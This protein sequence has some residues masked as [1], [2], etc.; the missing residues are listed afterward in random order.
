MT[1]SSGTLSQFKASSQHLKDV[2][3]F[4]TVSQPLLLRSPKLLICRSVKSIISPCAWARCN[5]FQ[6]RRRGI[7]MPNIRLKV[8]RYQSWAKDEHDENLRAQANEQRRPIPS[9]RMV[10]VYCAD[11]NFAVKRNVHPKPIW[12]DH[13][14]LV[15]L[16]VDYMLFIPYSTQHH[17]PVW[18]FRGGVLQHTNPSASSLARSLCHTE[19]DGFCLSIAAAA[20]AATAKK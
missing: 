16:A 19:A 4:D 1:L 12:N 15:A 14:P 7:I 17:E 10:V 6:H 8:R 2:A 18:A 11:R 9:R 20:A 3:T 13:L 5:P